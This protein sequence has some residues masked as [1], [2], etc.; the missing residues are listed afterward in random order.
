MKNILCLIPARFSSTRFPGKPLVEIN[1]IPM[2]WH[3]Y[4]KAIKSG[5]EHV[6]VATESQQIFEAVE[7][8]GGKVLMT[9]SSHL[10]GTDRCGEALKILQ[11]Q[12]FKF[13]FIINLQGDEPYIKPT[14]ILELCNGLEKGKITTLVKKI[15]EEEQLLSP[16][17]VKCIFSENEQLAIYFS[18]FPIPYI[19]SG[20]P[21]LA[22]YNYHK[23]IG[24][25]G[26]D[27]KIFEK[28]IKLKPTQLELAESLEQLRWLENDFKI[29]VVKTEMDSFGIDTPED[30]LN[31]NNSL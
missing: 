5:L 29:K 12:G 27:T 7:S 4:E 18:R 17:T 10:S 15:E 16:N 11:N 3:V 9:D 31:L 20:G 8:R 23:H 1:G 24:L 19:R 28:I 6:Y 25:Y 2:I 30:L 26:F 21:D 14:Q 13:D 22:K